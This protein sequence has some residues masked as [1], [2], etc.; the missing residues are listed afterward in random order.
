M[1]QR[2]VNFS[3]LAS[4]SVV[5]DIAITDDSISGD[6]L[7]AMLKGGDAATSIHEGG[8]VIR[9]PSF[10]TIGQVFYSDTELEFTDFQM[11][12]G[13]DESESALQPFDASH[14]ALAGAIG[15]Y[16]SEDEDMSC[17]E[18]LHIFKLAGNSSPLGVTL[19]EG[20]MDKTG[21]QLLE[22]IGLMTHGLMN[23]MTIA[24]DAGKKGQELV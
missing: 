17:D 1:K 15:E 2:L 13:E 18:I 23:L 22:D 24:H 12:G 20:S 21:N 5:Q 16:V 6:V 3:F 7:V 9:L 11:E 4:G 10:E 8:D 14:L 19:E